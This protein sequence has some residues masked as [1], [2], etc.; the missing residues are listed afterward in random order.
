MTKHSL[1]RTLAALLLAGMLLLP[2]LLAADVPVVQDTYISAAAPATNFGNAITLNIAPGNSGL[3]Q[4]DLS[5]IPAS[6][7]VP[8]AYLRVFVDKVTAGG[9]LTFSQ[10]TSAWLEAAVTF[11]G[12]AANAPF[13]TIPVSTANSFV[14]VDVTALVNGWLAS[15][16]T[17]FGIEIAGTGGTT[18]FLDSKEN[19]ATSHPAAVELSVTGPAGAAGTAGLPGANGAT[20]AAGP[21]GPTGV[22]GPT[23]ATGATGVL[24]P[25]GAIGPQG[26]VGLAGAAGAQGP[27]GLTGPTGP[28]GPTGAVGLAGAAGVAGPV[29]V[30]GPVGATG[31]SGAQGAAGGPGIGGPIGP[32]G[33]Q[34]TNGPTSNTFAFDTTVHASGYSIPDTDT[35]IYYLVNNAG[36]G[37]GNLTLPH[38]AVAGRRLLAIPANAATVPTPCTVANCRVQVI[39]QAGDTIFGTGVA[40]G[41]ASFPAPGPVLMFSDGNHH[42]FI[43]AF[44]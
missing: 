26:A 38:A 8:V 17:N 4:V 30:V 44:Q 24:G 42:W 28:I 40:A 15:P 37:P 23:G 3:M 32:T 21:A 29:G 41:Q 22:K 10:V 31:P 25:T 18:V 1:V 14:F 9:S 33:A 11:P 19:T 27:T 20:G 5:S 7:T 43:I 35:F 6:S 12:P 39:A 36:G 2:A 34:G 13:A 16:A